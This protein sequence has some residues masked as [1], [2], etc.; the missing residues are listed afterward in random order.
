MDVEARVAKLS[1]LLGQQLHT[2]HGVAENDGLVDAQLY[3][4]RGR[5]RAW[6]GKEKITGRA[7]NECM[8]ECKKRKNDCNSVGKAIQQA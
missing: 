8:Q 4:G 5:G 2:V 1:D 6:R 3:K 7:T